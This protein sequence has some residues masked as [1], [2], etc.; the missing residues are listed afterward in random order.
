MD[1]DFE[2]LDDEVAGRL[3]HAALQAIAA[4]SEL[5]PLQKAWRLIREVRAG[6]AQRHRR[7]E[8]ES[9]RA[10]GNLAE[11]CR[12]LGY[13][14][15]SDEIVREMLGGRPPRRAEVDAYAAGRRQAVLDLQ[16]RDM[17]EALLGGQV[18]AYLRQE[19]GLHV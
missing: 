10:N 16:M 12:R 13:Y 9:L 5:P 18:Q 6:V 19:T 14:A 17:D 1:I 4:T 7:A 8:L 11:L 2:K 15:S 3:I